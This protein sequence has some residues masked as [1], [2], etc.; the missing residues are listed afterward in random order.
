MASWER[1]QTT[2]NI[3]LLLTT[4][5]RGESISL[6]YLTLSPPMSPWYLISPHNITPKSP[7]EVRRIKEMIT[8]KRNSRLFI[9]FSLSAALE[10]FREQ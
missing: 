10:M 9:K 1:K 6:G 4:T 5:L 2:I 3:Y 8:N 7:I